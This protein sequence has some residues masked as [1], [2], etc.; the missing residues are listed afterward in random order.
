MVYTKEHIEQKVLQYYDIDKSVL[1]CEGQRAQLVEPRKFIFI[2]CRDLT[3]L[4]FAKIGEGY[5]GGSH[6]NV[7][8][9]SRKFQNWIDTD[10]KYKKKYDGIHELITNKKGNRKKELFKAFKEVYGIDENSIDKFKEDFNN[11]IKS[12]HDKL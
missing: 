10:K 12:D 9:T 4:S 1:T 3:K 2:F 5:K 8:T 7:L 6:C 11:F